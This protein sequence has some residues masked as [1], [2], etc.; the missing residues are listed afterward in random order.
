[1]Q[2]EDQTQNNPNTGFTQSTEP[3][4]SQARKIG[5]GLIASIIIVSVLAGALA[6]FGASLYTLKNRSNAASNGIQNVTVQEDSAIIDVVKKASPAVVSI[7]ISQNVNAQSD[8]SNN[9]FSPFFF[10]PFFQT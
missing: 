10:N 5:T 9:P 6:G 2:L 8:N 1:M 7:V 4:G 3:Y